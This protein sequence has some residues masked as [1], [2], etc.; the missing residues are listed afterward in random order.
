MDCLTE[1]THGR[2]HKRI[3]VEVRKS[4]LHKIFF[5]QKKIKVAAKE[6]K[7]NYSSA[8][9]ILHLYRKN[10]RKNAKAPAMC[11][12]VCGF[13]PIN[14]NDST[15]LEYNL[16]VSQGGEVIRKM[17]HIAVER[18]HSNFASSN[19]HPFLGANEVCTESDKIVIAIN[20][21]TDQI[22]ELNRLNMLV[23]T[24]MNSSTQTPTSSPTFAMSAFSKISGGCLSLLQTSEEFQKEYIS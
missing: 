1:G 18:I 12:N 13:R 7:L 3:S 19:R 22:R 11:S 9:T 6:L 23:A 5:E 2:R 10:M 21:L 8:K 24:F 17:K 4:L 16:K 15:T 14:Q 20:K